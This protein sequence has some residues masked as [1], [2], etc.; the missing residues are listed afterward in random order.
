MLDIIAGSPDAHVKTTTLSEEASKLLLAGFGVAF[1]AERVVAD[2]DGA[3][4]ASAYTQSD[5]LFL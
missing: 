5:F 3:V 2:V 1:G 4:N